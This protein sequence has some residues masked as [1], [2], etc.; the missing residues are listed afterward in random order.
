MIEIKHTRADGTLAEGTIKGD[1]SGDILK[2]N[3]FRWFPSLGCFGIV[4]SR[5]KR[6]KTWKINCAVE[7]LRAA[8]FEV[9]VTIDEETTRTFAEA[10]AERTQ[11]AEDRA[12]RFADRADR[13]TERSNSRYEASHAVIAS[14]PPGQPIL[15][16][17]H[18]ERGH[19][20]ALARSD[21][22]MRASIDEGNKAEYFERRADA[23][24][25][26]Q[27][28]RENTGTTLRRIEGLEADRRRF[29]RWRVARNIDPNAT[30]EV[31][32]RIAEID[33]QLAYWREVIAKQEADGVKIWGRDDFAKGDFVLFH[34]TWYEVLRVNPKSVTIP[35]M[36]SDGV[37]VGR[38]QVVRKN[39]TRLSWDDR[40]PYH[41]VRGRR[42]AEEMQAA[43]EEAE[44]T[45]S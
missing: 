16:G 15:V 28:H 11:R 17:H 31:N 12:D 29:E 5:D 30:A 13:A 22:H 41:K 35:A 32:R 26:Y 23:S 40:V 19:R 34:G 43:V 8:G 4:Q 14:I 1:G 39:E 27:Q 10:E 37:R 24:A 44:K 2:R 33:E 3:G 20:R 21:A 45:T 6:A 38:L 9:T 42:S 25:N 18:S 36:I 7:A